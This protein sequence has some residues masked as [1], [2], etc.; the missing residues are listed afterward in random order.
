GRG[1]VCL[2]PRA[3]PTTR[4]PAAP[5]PMAPARRNPRRDT[6]FSRSPAI[7]SPQMIGVEVSAFE[8]LGDDASLGRPV[9]LLVRG[10]RTFRDAEVGAEDRNS[11]GRDAPGAQERT[12]TLVVRYFRDLIERDDAL[13]QLHRRPF[14][15]ATPHNEDERHE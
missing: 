8:L 13:R 14:P 1:F 3:S 6:R 4:G 7:G 2:R 9:G 12:T 11:C 10:F 5:F 15:P